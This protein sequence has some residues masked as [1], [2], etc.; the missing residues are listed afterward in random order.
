MLIVDKMKNDKITAMNL[1]K[2][3]V[4]YTYI[5]YLHYPT[6]VINLFILM[7]ILNEMLFN[8]NIYE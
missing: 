5:H 3:L 7:L 2:G 8:Y 1:K 6:S 4:S